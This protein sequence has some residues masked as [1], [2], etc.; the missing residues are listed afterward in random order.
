MTVNSRSNIVNATLIAVNIVTMIK[1]R[2]AQ[3]FNSSK[4][5]ERNASE[6]HDFKNL[7]LPKG[8]I[9]QNIVED[10]F[11]LCNHAEMSIDLKNL[12]CAE[13]N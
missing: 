13:L 4:N 12:K 10:I 2:K 9:G 3:K 6:V 8:R 5:V 11:D 7:D 1:L